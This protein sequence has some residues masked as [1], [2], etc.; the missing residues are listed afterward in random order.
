MFIVLIDKQFSYKVGPHLLE[1][2]CTFFSNRYLAF[3]ISA[4]KK[5]LF[6]AEE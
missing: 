6:L 4:R 1:L 2:T 5:K 3:V